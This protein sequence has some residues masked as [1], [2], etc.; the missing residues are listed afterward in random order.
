MR[1]SELS[2]DPSKLVFDV[3]IRRGAQEYRRFMVA[4]CRGY[5]QELLTLVRLIAG[6]T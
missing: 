2:G 1:P 5:E 4:Q 3:A 6:V